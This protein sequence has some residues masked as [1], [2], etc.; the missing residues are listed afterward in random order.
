MVTGGTTGARRLHQPHARE[1][2]RGGGKTEPTQGS[3]PQAG[4]DLR[5]QPGLVR[6]RLRHVVVGEPADDAGVAGA[7]IALGQS[8]GADIEVVQHIAEVLEGRGQ[9]S[10]DVGVGELRLLGPVVK[11]EH[12]ARHHLAQPHAEAATAHRHPRDEAA[13]G[14][15]AGDAAR[16][17][18]LPGGEPLEDD[19]RQG[20]GAAH[21][22]EGGQAAHPLH[23][24]QHRRGDVLVAAREPLGEDPIGDEA[25]DDPGQR[26]QPVGAAPVV[27]LAARVAPPR[28]AQQG[29]GRL[30]PQWL[31]GIEQKSGEP[32]L[33]KLG[34]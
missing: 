28:L 21:A 3:H 8:A 20:G 26:G 9:I 7:Q 34:Q 17:L 6:A 16:L 13:L 29:L 27:E 10:V 4:V 33:L 22:Y 14:Q 2:D 24:V 30:D 11:G 12:P 15:R 5:E 19:D 31:A 25:G 18:A 23:V 32:A 1:Q